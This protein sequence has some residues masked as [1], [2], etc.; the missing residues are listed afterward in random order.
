MPAAP[1]AQRAGIFAPSPTC[2]IPELAQLYVQF[3]GDRRDGVVV[4]VGAFDGESY[5]NSSCLVDVGWRALL[6]EPVPEFA[7]RCRAHH[8]GNPRV[9]VVSVAVGAEN[10]TLTLEVAGALTSADTE[11]MAEYARTPWSAATVASRHSL[12]VPSRRLD[13]LLEE[14]A[15]APGFD[16]LIVDVEGCE[17]QVFA[18]FELERWRP[19][20]MIWELS[21]THPDLRLHRDASVAIARSIVENGY[22]IV[23]KDAINTVFLR[24]DGD[25]AAHH[26]SR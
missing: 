6:V 2:Q 3:F 8:V 20:L 13:D 9:E 22:R 26:P 5:S 25:A 14:H 4:E 18:G 10:A 19:T 17:A 23:Y 12:T 7:L 24:D 15:V 11:Q 16:V 1:K 21:D